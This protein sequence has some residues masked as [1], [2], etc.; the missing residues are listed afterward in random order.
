MKKRLFAAFVSLCMIVSML[1]TMAF[2]EAG[3][4]DS[5]NPATPSGA[6]PE[7]CTCKTLCTEEE[8]NADCPVCSAEGAAPEEVCLGAAPMLG[9]AAP[10]SAE[11]SGHSGWKE[12]VGYWFNL[13][14]GNYV[15]TG[16]LFVSNIL[17][18]RDVT[19]CLNGHNIRGEGGQIVNLTICDC[20]GNGRISDAK[21]ECSLSDVS[22]SSCEII[23]GTTIGGNSKIYSG[24]TIRDMTDMS[25]NS[26]T[27]VTSGVTINVNR[28]VLSLNG[29][30]VQSAVNVNGG[31]CNI[32]GGTEIENFTEGAPVVYVNSGICNISG[33]TISSR[34]VNEGTCDITGGTISSS[35]EVSGG[36][37]NITGGTIKVYDYT[38]SGETTGAVVVKGGSCNIGGDAQITGNRIDNG[39][40]VSVIGGSCTISG[41]N[42]DKNNTKYGGVYVENGTCTIEEDASITSNQAFDQGGGVYVAGGV[43]DIY[44]TIGSNYTAYN[45]DGDGGGVYVAGGECNI[46]GKIYNNTAKRDGGGVYVADGNCN[47]AATSINYNEAAGNGGGIYV[48]GG[49]CRIATETI[50][51]NTA[52]GNGGGVYVASGA[53]VTVNNTS[54]GLPQIKYNTADGNGGGVYLC[55]GSEWLNLCDVT[56]NTAQYGGGIYSEGDCK[57]TIRNGSV[58]GNTATVEGGGLYLNDSQTKPCNVE[59]TNWT[60]KENKDNSS[61]PN[62][63]VSLNSQITYEQGLSTQDTL[64]YEEPG[65]IILKDSAS[66]TIMSGKYE[67]SEISSCFTRQSDNKI[68]I[69]GGYYDADPSKEPTLTVVDGVKAIELDGDIGYNQYDPN[70]PWA[71]YPVK[72][73][74]MSGT[75]NNPV[76]NGA[77]IEQDSGFSLSGATDIQKFYYWHKSQGAEDSTYISGLPSDAGD[78]TIKVGGLHLRTIGEEYYTECTFDL[79]IAKAA[80]SYTVPTGI[81]AQ[82][83]E[84]LSTVTLPEGWKW[85]DEST[86]PQAEGTQIYPAIFTPDDTDNYNIVETDISVEVEHAHEGVLR[87]EVPATCT[88]TGE[89]AYYECSI[90]HQY[91][92]DEACNNPIT[93]LDSWKV[94]PV[95]GHDFGGWTSNGNGTHTGTCQRDGCDATDTQN[96]SGGEATYFLKAKCEICGGAYGELKEDTTLPTGEIRINENKWNKF[97]NTITFGLFF[98]ETQSVVITADDD[99]YSVAGYTDDKAAVIEYYLYDGDTALSQEELEDKEFTTYTGSLNMEPNGKY[100][101][102]VRITDH[103]GNKTYISSD[104]IVLYTDAKQ[105][106]ESISFVK[107]TTE[108]VTASV[109]TNGNTVKEIRNGAT[110]LSDSDYS[111]SYEGNKA[112]ITFKAVYLDTLAAGGYTLTLSYNPL[113]ME[114]QDGDGSEAPSNTTITLTVNQQA[115][116]ITNISDIS[117]IYDDTAVSAPTYD[118]LSTGTAVIEYKVKDADDST[119][120]QTAPNTVGEY[121]VRIT[122]AADENYAEASATRDFTISYLAAPQEPYTLIGSTGTNGWYTGDVTLKPADGYTVST[123]LNGTYSDQL[124]FAQTTEGFTIY[125]K[126]SVGQMTDAITVGTIKIDKTAPDG[127]ILFEKNSVK[128]FINN[129]SFGLFFNKDIDVEI[130]GTD[131]LSGVAKIE[132]YRSDKALTEAEVAAITDWMETNGKFSVTAE[133]Q[134]NFICYV[135]ITDQAGNQTYFGSDGATFDTTKPVI[136]GIADGKIYCEEQTFTVEETNLESVLIDGVA[137]TPDNTGNYTL[138]AGNKQYTITVTDK[139]GNNTLC[140]VTVNDGHDWNEAIYTWNDNGSSCTASRTCKNDSDHVE[141]AEAN[142]TSKPGKEPTC[143]ENGETTYTAA[144]EADW[145]MTQTKVLADIPATGHS[146]DNG[147][148]TVCGAIASDFK[149]IITAGAN[150]SWQKGTKDGLAFTSNAAYKHFQKVQ[151]DGQDLDVS[152]YTVKEG[153]TIVT[154]KAEYLETLSVGKHTLSI[155]SDTGTAT[156]EFTIKAAAVT[157]DTQSPQ[158]GDNSNLI[159]WV[160]LLAG[161]GILLTAVVWYDRRCKMGHRK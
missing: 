23:G 25:I 86:I 51:L 56:Y 1:P 43:C 151:V 113:G 67:A 99:S 100:T 114:Y 16:D 19:I 62:N 142:I 132:Y 116:T 158:T 136:K 157:D 73:G 138:P 45:Y 69:A 27:T 109:F 153:S 70:Y 7:E 140:T 33:G 110:V 14:P 17:S 145:A 121:T 156:T 30:D 4:Q 135:K 54:A 154:L 47:I 92:E 93:D 98:K 40:A 13:D 10:L 130:T 119:Y 131:D 46:Y 49:E 127:D 38:S 32:G 89:K 143:T 65:S 29:A 26:G 129:I 101:I 118:S 85:K 141:T 18:A 48:A 102:Y 95:L 80:P 148:C 111:V 64:P 96:C 103:A 42:I 61:R 159:M 88:Q 137:A 149:V 50:G 3:A 2:A 160:G 126:N 115:G 41:G 52:A 79:T 112:T 9:A 12:I 82:V 28:G 123:T 139:A 59:I 75:S 97:L 20:T 84:P 68:L 150:G 36:T 24:C 120:T 155:V 72:D 34:I 60:I 133:D 66:F 87:E 134:V 77:P 117:K 152:N 104:G 90:C 8:V 122:V 11:H 81:T 15:L 37:C 63:M 83:G 106:T 71:V 107:T 78:Y 58:E 22:L 5:G 144:F 53:K 21:I 31:T 76:Y 105:D 147:K 74:I 94:I 128:E 108:D 146:Y 6:Q 55:E 161:F 124:D 44:G 125:L 91:F 57:L 39:G 35:I